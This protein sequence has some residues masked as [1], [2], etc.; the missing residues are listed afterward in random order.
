MSHSGRGLSQVRHRGGLAGHHAGLHARQEVRP[1]VRAGQQ[2]GGGDALR[3]QLCRVLLHQLLHALRLP[4]ERGGAGGLGCWA[5]G[6]GQAGKAASPEQSNTLEGA[7]TGPGELSHTLLAHSWLLPSSPRTGGHLSTSGTLM[8][9]EGRVV[10]SVP[11]PWQPRQAAGCEG[12]LPVH[13]GVHTASLRGAGQVLSQESHVPGAGV[14]VVPCGWPFGR[15][16]LRA[17]GPDS[18]TCRKG[19]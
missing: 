1:R 12:K 2:H 13:S 5:C 3:Q 14:S 8:R 19:H 16:G 7:G 18:P 17:R 6:P 9:S 11:C 10:D 15:A 4:G